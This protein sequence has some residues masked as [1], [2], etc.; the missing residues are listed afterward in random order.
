MYTKGLQNCGPGWNAELFMSSNLLHKNENYIALKCLIDCRLK[1]FDIQRH[2]IPQLKD[3][4]H[5]NIR[6]QG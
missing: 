1:S 4:A 5:A 3:L 6:K 2:I